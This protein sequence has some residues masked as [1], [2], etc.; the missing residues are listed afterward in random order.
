M[1]TK[2]Q[3]SLNGISCHAWNKDKS[4]VAICPNNNEIHIYGNCQNKS[5][6]RLHV[7]GEHDLLVS[8]LDWSSVH[9]KI[10]SCSHD[11]NAFVWTFDEASN[12]WKP[13]LV[14][15]RIDRAAIQVKWSLDGAKF[16]VTSSAKC[17]P[18]CTYEAANDWWVSKTIRKK[19]KSTVLC[20]AFHPTNPQLLAV[21]S[22]DFKCK[23]F[24]AFT[25]DVDVNGVVCA[26]FASPLEFG[27]IYAEMSSLGWVNAVA[28]SPSGHTLCY[29]GQD[30]SIHFVNFGQDGTPLVQSLRF[31]QLPCT[32]LLYTSEFMVVGGGYDFNPLLFQYSDGKGSWEVNR[33][34]EKKKAETTAAATGGVAAA[35]AL[36]Q[37]KSKLGQ[38]SKAATDTLWTSHENT[39]NC[40]QDASTTAGKVTRIST[41][42]V[43]GTV[44][45]WD[46][47]DNSFGE[48]SI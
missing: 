27:E 18:V 13:A 1:T 14:I 26:P 31:S 43:D 10:V 11:R 44:V 16:A 8:G 23:I 4:M 36:F 28:W 47:L 34:L 5:W 6:E 15:L 42:G 40:I 29:A 17:V 45:M 38:D 25:S 33:F 21:G 19:I 20:C 35:R 9:N 39:I 46:L 3:L 32:S 24:S 7:L 48:L 2:H 12:S 22:S 41:S 30:S 37:N